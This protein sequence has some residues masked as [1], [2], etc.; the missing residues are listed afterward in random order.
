MWPTAALTLSIT[1]RTAS[2]E[3]LF[4][5]PMHLPACS[6]AGQR[7]ALAHYSHSYGHGRHMQQRHTEACW[8]YHNIKF[9]AASHPPP[10]LPP[11]DHTGMVYRL[12]RGTCM[13]NALQHRLVGHG[14]L[15][16]AHDGSWYA[17]QALQ[18]S[19]HSICKRQCNSQIQPKPDSHQP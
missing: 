13:S 3:M 7:S 19:C 6:R 9:I 18:E 12:R 1:C 10:G 8:H 4:R 2:V 15:Q 5:L 14:R 11:A 16:H 17:S